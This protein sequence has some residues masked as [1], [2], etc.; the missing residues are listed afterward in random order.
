MVLYP[1]GYAARRKEMVGEIAGGIVREMVGGMVREMVREKSAG[2]RAFL[3]M[4]KNGKVE[5]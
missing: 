2:N 4:L 1:R 5:T 3:G